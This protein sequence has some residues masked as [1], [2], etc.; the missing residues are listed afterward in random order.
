MDCPWELLVK[1][2]LHRMRN[3]LVNIACFASNEPRYR[4]NINTVF[5]GMRFPFKRIRCSWYRVIFI[6]RIPNLVRRRRCIKTVPRMQNRFSLHSELTLHETS[7]ITR[8]IRTSSSWNTRLGTL[9]PISCSYPRHSQLTRHSLML[10]NG[11]IRQSL[12]AL[13]FIWYPGDTEKSS[14]RSSVDSITKGM[15][16][17]TFTFSLISASNQVSVDIYCRQTCSEKQQT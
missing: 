9:W 12:T 3:I 16:C 8:T 6:M 15:F 11:R 10:A 5:S 4:L 13:V 17:G 14:C 1:R 7:K 2:R